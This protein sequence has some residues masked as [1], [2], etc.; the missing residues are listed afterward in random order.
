GLSA[1]KVPDRQEIRSTPC[2]DALAV[3]LD[4]FQSALSAGHR[5]AKHAGSRPAERFFGYFLCA[6][7]K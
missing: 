6:Q 5:R 4:L 2:V 1:P 3:D 7:R